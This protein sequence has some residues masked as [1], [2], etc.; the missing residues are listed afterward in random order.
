MSKAAKITRNALTTYSGRGKYNPK[1]LNHNV[2]LLSQCANSF[3]AVQF[4]HAET[5]FVD[6]C[7]KNFVY[8]NIN[9]RYFPN[10]KTIYCNSHPCESMVLKR[11]HDMYI[12]ENNPDEITIYLTEQW[13]DMYK[14]KWFRN[15]EYIKGITKVE[16]YKIMGSYEVEELK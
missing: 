6:E 10:V 5:L 11:H 2:V 13:M 12:Q 1:D 3:L 9:T 4:P 16:M 7:E 8:Y 15:E 14:Q